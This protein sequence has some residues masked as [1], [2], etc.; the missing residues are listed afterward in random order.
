MITGHQLPG[1]E[2]LD[3][4][5]GLQHRIPAKV[6]DA[7]AA[8]AQDTAHQILL[9]QHGACL[10]LMGGIVTVMGPAAAGTD[11]LVC[12]LHAAITAM[13][14]QKIQLLFPFSPVY[15]D[16][17]AISTAKTE[18]ISPFRFCFVRDPGTR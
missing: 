9:L 16:H 6:S 5:R 1:I 17:P 12:Q 15:Y 13:S 10:Q 11:R 7:E 18:R 4:H 8:L 3:G 14:F 2:F